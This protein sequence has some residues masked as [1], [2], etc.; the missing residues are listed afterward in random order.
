[1]GYNLWLNANLPFETFSVQTYITE[2]LHYK[3]KHFAFEHIAGDQDQYLVFGKIKVPASESDQD[4]I[5]KL[6][7]AS[8]PDPF[9]AKH[10]RLALVE[11]NAEQHPEM[12]AS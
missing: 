6:R 8:E 7:G 12:S 3:E 4:L 10:L 5:V 1:M 2:H 11:V 9:V